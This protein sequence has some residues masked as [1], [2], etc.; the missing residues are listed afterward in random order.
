MDKL[1]AHL[2]LAFLVSAVCAVLLRVMRVHFALKATA[3]F[4][5]TTA[6]VCTAVM[7]DGSA[8][9]WQD[10]LLIASFFSVPA[11]VGVVLVSAVMAW[12]ANKRRAR[13]RRKAA[14]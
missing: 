10:A 3:N 14:I 6:V 11:S 13:G 12:V 8:P 4:A 9:P 2:L 5:I 1:I 7:Q